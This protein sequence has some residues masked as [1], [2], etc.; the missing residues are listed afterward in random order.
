MLRNRTQL[1]QG[2]PDGD[3][4]V[5]RVTHGTSSRFQSCRQMPT[6]IV[7]EYAAKRL[8]TQFQNHHGSL[9]SIGLF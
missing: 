4:S 2:E 8:L 7:S 6:K 3:L 5:D 1:A 9:F